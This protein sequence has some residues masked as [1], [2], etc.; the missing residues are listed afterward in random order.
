MESEG[1]GTI[2]YGFGRVMRPDR[3]R[4]R[5]L[6]WLYPYGTIPRLLLFWMTTEALRTGSRQLN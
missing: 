6:H 4:G 5:G 1:T 3:K 2:P